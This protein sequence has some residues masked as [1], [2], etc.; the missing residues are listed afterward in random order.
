MYAI[1]SYYALEANSVDA[2]D[3]DVLFARDGDI[4]LFAVCYESMFGAIF[5]DEIIVYL[6]DG[7]VVKCN[8]RGSYD[9]VDN[10]AKAVYFLTGDQLDKVQNSNIHTVRYTLEVEPDDD[11]SLDMEWNRSASNQGIQTKTIITEFLA[12]KIMDSYN[13]V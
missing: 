8:N 5:S 7:T 4:G 9:Y 3:L 12:G 13:F 2:N 6:Q 11:N 10:R 1:R